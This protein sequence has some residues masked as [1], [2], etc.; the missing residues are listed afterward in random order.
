MNTLKDFY[1]TA[2]P[3]FNEPIICPACGAHMSIKE[4]SSYKMVLNKKARVE[5]DA[6]LRKYATYLESLEFRMMLHNLEGVRSLAL[7]DCPYKR[8]AELNPGLANG[9]FKDTDGALAVNKIFSD[10]LDYFEENRV[11]QLPL[12]KDIKNSTDNDESRKKMLIRHAVDVLNVDPSIGVAVDLVFSQEYVAKWVQKTNMSFRDGLNDLCQEISPTWHDYLKALEKY[13]DKVILEKVLRVR[14]V[15]AILRGHCTKNNDFA[16]RQQGDNDENNNVL[17]RPLNIQQNYAYRLPNKTYVSIDMLRYLLLSPILLDNPKIGFN[18][19]LRREIRK[20][21]SKEVREEKKETSAFSFVNELNHD[22]TDDTKRVLVDEKIIDRFSDL[23]F[24][25]VENEPEI[26][27]VVDFACSNTE[28]GISC[29]WMPKRDKTHS[30]VLLGS[31]GTSKSTALLTGITMFYQN[32]AAIGAEVKFVT[33]EDNDKID[34]LIR[35]YWD[36]WLPQ[37]TPVGERTSIELT[38]AFHEG[39]VENKSNYVFIDVA[40]QRVVKC[41]TKDGT[42]SA[43]LGILKNAETIVFFYD[44]TIE[45]QI[46]EKLTAAALGDVWKPLKEHK[47]SVSEHRKGEDKGGKSTVDISQ[48]QLLRQLIDDLQSQATADDLI[49]NKNFI[50]VVPKSDMFYSDNVAEKERFFLTDY[51]VKSRD[52]KLV[53]PSIN[54]PKEEFKQ[55]DMGHYWTQIGADLFLN[56]KNTQVNNIETQ[57]YVIRQL[58]QLCKKCI[59]NLGNSVSEKSGEDEDIYGVKGA[60]NRYIDTLVNTIERTFNNSYFLAISAKGSNEIP[61]KSSQADANGIVYDIYKHAPRQKFSEYV[62]AIPVILTALKEAKS[63]P[64]K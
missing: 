13:D 16:L 20:K 46:H 36:G 40:G 28:N 25:W 11:K 61:D 3:E 6:C 52:F 12:V 17:L 9:V 35:R 62:F 19:D 45:R 4:P 15:I 43:L 37:A 53:R 31:P 60:L 22:R 47:D 55:D 59:L 8:L 39:G 57:E 1:K 2:L 14:Y 41:V 23:L 54:V 10:S 21:D 48:D 34:A 44:F 42:E 18:E 50:F 51:F 27:K 63:T 33:P 56:G 49:S 38:V 24:K 64:Y 26:S 30:V 5:L 7:E 58:S 32:A 29:E